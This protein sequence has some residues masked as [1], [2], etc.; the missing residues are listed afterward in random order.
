MLHNYA[1]DQCTLNKQIYGYETSSRNTLTHRL[2]QILY[3]VVFAQIITLQKC[4]TIASRRIRFSM[5]REAE[6]HENCLRKIFSE[7]YNMLGT[8]STQ[9]IKTN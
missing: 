4:N 3:I 8:R 1:A 6:I 5:E 2:V 7:L 9:Q